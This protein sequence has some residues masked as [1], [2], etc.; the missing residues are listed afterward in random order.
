MIRERGFALGRSAV[1]PARPAV[2]L[3]ST[4]LVSAVT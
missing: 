2:I 3:I 4:H 1:L